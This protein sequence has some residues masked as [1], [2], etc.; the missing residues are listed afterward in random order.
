MLKSMKPKQTFPNNTILWILVGVLVISGIAAI[1][2]AFSGGDS[3]EDD[4][5]AVYT[6]A[7]A[8]LTVQ[9]MTMQAASPSV[10]P[11]TVTQTPTVTFTPLASPTLFATL[12]SSSGST[13]STGG[14]GAV[15]CNNSI[16]LSDVTFQDNTVVSP[17]QAMTKTWKLQN[18]GSCAWTP[19][20]KVS[21]VSGNAMGGATT[22]IGITVQPGQSGDISVAMT[23]PTTAGDAKGTWI[24]TNDS[25]QNFGTTFF[26]LV[27]VGSTSSAGTATATATATNTSAPSAPAAVGSVNVTLQCTSDGNGNFDYSGTT[28]SWTDQSN[29]ENGFYIYI[30]NQKVSPD[31]AANT[32]TY[33][34]AANTIFPAGS[35]IPFGVA[36][37]NGVGASNIV[38]TIS[39]CQ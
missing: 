28:I 32:T 6:N 11:T 5:N 26:I 13:G 7:A 18:T 35:Q 4:V 24:L 39:G 30:N 2:S 27:K 17:G 23:A 38:S 16:L 9:A 1:V 12:P 8:T 3:G 37:Y 14:S 36:S 22:P 15:G 33:T 34:V 19:T 31:A 20:Y 29:N 10:T 21:F 25:G